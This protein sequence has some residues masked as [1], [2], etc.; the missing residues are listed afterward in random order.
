MV[1]ATQRY[2]GQK[3]MVFSPTLRRRPFMQ[4]GGG[5]D[6]RVLKAHSGWFRVQSPENVAF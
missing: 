5:G 1:V 6:L 3:R 2:A 4:M